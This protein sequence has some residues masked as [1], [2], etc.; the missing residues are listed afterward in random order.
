VFTSIAISGLPGQPKNLTRIV[1]SLVTRPKAAGI[2]AFLDGTLVVFPVLVGS[3]VLSIVLA[4]DVDA[5]VVLSGKVVVEE[6][7]EGTRVE[8]YPLEGDLVVN[9]EKVRGA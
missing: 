8:S 4:G 3:I 9:G 1:P 6:V 2:P 7:L 5:A